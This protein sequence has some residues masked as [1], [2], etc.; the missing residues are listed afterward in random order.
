MLHLEIRDV[1]GILSGTAE[2]RELVIN[3]SIFR[4][5]ARQE[6]LYDRTEC[7]GY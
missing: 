3:G 7:F 5:S 2:A 1:P 4:C 6:A